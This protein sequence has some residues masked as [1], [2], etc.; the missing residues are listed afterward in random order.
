MA[1][2]T[3]IHTSSAEL[4]AAEFQAGE[5]LDRTSAADHIPTVL[6]LIR[7]ARELLTESELLKRCQDAARLELRPPDFTSED[8]TDCAAELVWQVL[9]ERNGSPPKRSA[10]EATLT[11]FCNRAKNWR[12]AEINRRRAEQRA[13]E[14]VE[15]KLVLSA[16]AEY[17]IADDLNQPLGYRIAAAEQAA[18]ELV[19]RL[20]LAQ[21]GPVWAALYERARD[22]SAEQCAAEQ[23]VSY[24][25][26]RKR[27]QRGAAMLRGIFPN[28]SDLLGFL[29]PAADEVER[30]YRRPSHVRPTREGTNNG[31]RPMRATDASEARE[32]SSVRHQCPTPG[33]AAVNESLNRRGHYVK[34]PALPSATT[35]S[36]ERRPAGH[37]WIAGRT[38]MQARADSLR[39]L[40]RIRASESKREQSASAERSTATEA[41]AGQWDSLTA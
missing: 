17:E 1:R 2:K 12:N 32:L 8:R 20:A 18:S 3:A 34:A 6:E 37:L 24:E 16:A 38:A 7:E 39:E 19:G 41:V 30:I 5:R 10:P 36:G 35:E 29:D 9:A 21:R 28:A 25:T 26:W 22:C 31:E 40:G 13:R 15:D 23:N 14:A 27:T 4:A 11:Y 33:L